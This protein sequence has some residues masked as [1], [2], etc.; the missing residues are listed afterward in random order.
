MNDTPRDQL[1]R[2]LIVDDERLQIDT[3]VAAIR[4]FYKVMVAHNGE[5]ALKAAR[6]S[7]PPDLVLLDIVMPGMDGYAVCHQL[8]QDDKTCAIP[9][10]FITSKNEA[11]DET[12]G[13]DLGAVDYISKPISV[14]VVRARIRTHLALSAALKSQEEQNLNRRRWMADISHELRTPLAVLRAQVEAM[15]D[16]IHPADAT[17]LGVLHG[18]VMGLSRL[19]DDLYLLARADLGALSVEMNPVEPLAILEDLL[20]SFAQRLAGAGITLE[21]HLP[22]ERPWVTLGDPR[23]LRHLLTNLVENSVRY[24]DAGGRLLVTVVVE[25]D[26]LL[27]RFDDTPPPVPVEELPRLF[28]RFYRAESSRSRDHGGSGLGLAI[29]QGIVAAHG[30]TIAAAP[31]PLGGLRIDVVLKKSV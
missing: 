20:E 7:P 17:T 5:Q 27:V 3:L 12:R 13:F 30:G 11:I 10:I 25:A 8:K 1:Q 26:A 28:D 29:C 21:M 4:P 2:I 16:G 22:A 31:S 14:A 23:R 24:T 15:Q 9:V 19:V 18:E 6:G